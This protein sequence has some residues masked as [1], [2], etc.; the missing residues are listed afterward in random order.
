VKATYDEVKKQLDLLIEALEA[1]NDADAEKAFKKI[2]RDMRAL[3]AS[4][5]VRSHG[6]QVNQTRVQQAGDFDRGAFAP[7]T[8]RSNTTTANQR[9]RKLMNHHGIDRLIRLMAKRA[10]LKRVPDSE[11][12]KV[13]ER[14]RKLND[15]L[16]KVAKHERLNEAAPKYV[17]NIRRK[18]REIADTNGVKVAPVYGDEV[19]TSFNDRL[20]ARRNN[21]D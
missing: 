2:S 16:T 14:D 9:R 21:S 11:S 6:H 1:E 18:H 3:I 8:S 13:R 15:A 7:N 12:L 4:F 17:Q 19:D 5:V 20:N 10:K